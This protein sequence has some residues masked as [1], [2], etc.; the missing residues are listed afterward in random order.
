[1]P[2]LQAQPAEVSGAGEIIRKETKIQAGPGQVYAE[3]AI[4]RKATGKVDK[5]WFLADIVSVEMNTG[6][7]PKSE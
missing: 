5:G 3:V 2:E 7:E 6:E 1:M 4:T